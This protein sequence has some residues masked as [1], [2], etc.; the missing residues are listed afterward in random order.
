[1][2]LAPGT[3]A[4]TVK[5]P[6]VVPAVSVGLAARPSALVCTAAVPPPPVKVAPAP[7]VVT[8]S[9]LTVAPATGSAYVSVTSTCKGVAN[10]SPIWADWPPP[11]LAVTD[12]TTPTVV[13][14][15]WNGGDEYPSKPAVTVYEPV[16]LLA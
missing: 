7:A 2:E 4:V 6:D 11:E 14:E 8:T 5:A 9:K 3:L 12:D 16:T 15:S 10:E 13:L 1:M